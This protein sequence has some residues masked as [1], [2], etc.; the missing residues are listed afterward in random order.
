MDLLFETLTKF[1]QKFQ[2]GRLDHGELEYTIP[3]MNTKVG[4]K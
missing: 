2:E 3:G 1:Q 4:W